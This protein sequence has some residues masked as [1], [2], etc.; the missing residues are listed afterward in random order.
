MEA[1]RQL[2]DSLPTP[3]PEIILTGD[4]N[5]PFL[6]WPERILTGSTSTEKSQAKLLLDIINSSFLVQVINEP[7]RGKNIIDLLFINN[8]DAIDSISAEKTIYSDHNLLR[9]F[10]NYRK[11][12]LP[13]TVTS[14]TEKNPFSSL[15]FF[16]SQ[17]NWE[18]INDQM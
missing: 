14:R 11:T 16:S 7:T 13:P 4:F 12:M 5:F 1:L 10:T 15:N 3:A 2:L 8:S 18:R 6:K 17:V 9:I